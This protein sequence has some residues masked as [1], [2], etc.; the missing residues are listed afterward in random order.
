MYIYVMLCL[1]TYNKY[2]HLFSYGHFFIYL[3]DMFLKKMLKACMVNIFI[4]SEIPTLDVIKRVSKNFK[5]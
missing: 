2:L 3:T 1:N 5:N 4:H